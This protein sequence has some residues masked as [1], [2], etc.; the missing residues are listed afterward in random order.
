MQSRGPVE[1]FRISGIARFGAV[2]S[3][4]GATLA[5]FDLPTAQSL[6]DKVGQLDQIRIA[7]KSGV[8]P[9]E[10]VAQVREILPKD[11]R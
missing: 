11:A 9:E 4:G 10:L 3:I 2:S 7:A 5:G 6:F 8:T 1:T